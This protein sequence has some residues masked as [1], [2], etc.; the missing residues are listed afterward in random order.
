MARTIRDVALGYSLLKGPDGIDGYAIH[1]RGAEP[2]GGGLAGQP[3]RVG[4]VS[5]AAFAPVNPEI[6]PRSPQR[7]INLPI[8]D[9]R[10]RT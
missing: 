3:I 4:W 9:A 5:D 7:R 8:S 6:T 2:D 10:W 1:A